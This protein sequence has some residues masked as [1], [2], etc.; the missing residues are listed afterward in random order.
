[1]SKATPNV[2][3]SPESASGVMPLERLD[4]QMIL[5][6]G[7]APAPA[8]VSVK[9]GNGEASQISVTYGLH[10]TGSLASARLTQSLASRYRAKTASLGS[11]LFRVIWKE[12]VTPSGRSIPAQR[13]SGHLTSGSGFTSWPSPLA[14]KSSP[15]Q[16]DDFTPNLAAT[17]QLAAWPTPTQQD[18]E[19]GGQAKRATN[20]ERSND[21]NDFAQLALPRQPGLVSGAA[22]SGS[23]AET[24]K[25][26]QLNPAFSRW[27]M[28]L[29]PEWDDCAVTATASLRRKPKP[30]SK[31][32]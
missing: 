18:G 10:G 9:S 26:G 30:S 3:S 16:R 4:G 13:A 31:R 32:T 14:N 1:M 7:Q 24:E 17:A 11:T 25:P 23:P 6:C 22:P 29:P 12:R 21:L 20:P 28:G 8:K 19:G 27:L 15:Q 5:Q 2:T